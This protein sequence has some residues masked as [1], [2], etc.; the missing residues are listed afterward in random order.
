VTNLIGLISRPFLNLE[1]DAP[2]KS[3][4]GD[5]LTASGMD[6]M[7][8][9]DALEALFQRITHPGWGSR[10]LLPITPEK[11]II[12]INSAIS[13]VTP[14]E[15]FRLRGVSL[16]IGNYFV[17]RGY[18]TEITSDY[19]APRASPTCAPDEFLTR[20][21]IFRAS[22]IV[23]IAD[24]GRLGTAT[25][26][27][28]AEDLLIPALVL[29]QDPV[30]IGSAR[31]PGGFSRRMARGYG[32]HRDAI[33]AAEDYLD[34]MGDYVANRNAKL[35]TWRAEDISEIRNRFLN[36]DVALFDASPVIYQRARFFTS[37]PILWTQCPPATRTEILRV[38]GLAGPATPQPE[39]RL[40][41]EASTGS[42]MALFVA[43]EHRGW[44]WDRVTA[45][46]QAYIG[47]NEHPVSPR[48][49]AWGFDDWIRFEVSLP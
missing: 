27:T 10:E 23:T 36:T 26:L 8:I 5:A 14:D 16:A 40:A 33:A 17:A 15:Y 31:Y 32:T 18:R 43:A 49:S 41:A 37:D 24:H 42:V 19:A 28:I 45:V 3:V 30:D 2:L 9:E 29:Y 47:L 39:R 48:K 46:Y 6:E 25:T 21:A 12:Q 44:T 7:Q 11:P 34:T 1:L 38:L 35:N 20:A 22:G 4:A 13:D